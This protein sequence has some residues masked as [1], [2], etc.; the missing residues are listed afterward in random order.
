MTSELFQSLMETDQSVFLYLNG[1]Y[2]DFGDYFMSTFSGKIIWVPMYASVL[3][4]LLKNANWKETLCCLIAIALTITF[5]DQMCAT[6]IRPVVARLRPCSP[7]NPISELVHLVNG[8]RSGSFSFPSCHASNSFGLAF[9]L[10]YLFRNRRLTLF[11][12]LWAVVNSYS[13]IYLGVH[14]PTDLL[15]GAIIGA[16]GATLMYFLLRQL[17]GIK[18]VSDKQ[19]S[20]II[21]T[22]LLTILGISV[23]ALIY[24]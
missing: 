17:T 11:I 13:R 12:M 19:A 14:Y 21:Y 24:G 10:M 9:M 23:Y 15:A 18:R 8:K 4:V 20:V 7:D 1:L 6:V 3:Y 2:T 16:V 22:G 5:A